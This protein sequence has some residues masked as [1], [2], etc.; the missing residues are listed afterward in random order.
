MKNSCL[1]IV[2]EWV[3]DWYNPDNDS[4]V[5]LIN[6]RGPSG[7]YKISKGI[8]WFYD[9]KDNNGEPL[10]FGIHMTEIRYQS[11]RETGN[12]GFGF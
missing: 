3:Y 1:I 8:S 12:N 4:L 2:S 11:P 9:S 5:S 6:P 7:E 10:K